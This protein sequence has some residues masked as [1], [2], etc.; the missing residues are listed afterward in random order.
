[1]L[2]HSSAGVAAAMMIA[3]E[4]EVC[5]S[6][7]L[8]ALAASMVRLESAQVTWQELYPTIVGRHA[9]VILP[10]RAVD[11]TYVYPYSRALS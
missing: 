8:L 9:A 3:V 4:P 10:W 1:M 7:L 6:Y 11:A 2:V 5:S